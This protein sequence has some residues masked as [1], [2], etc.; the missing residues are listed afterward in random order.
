MVSLEDIKKLT[1]KNA[2]RNNWILNKDE[3]WLEDLNKG[4]YENQ[5]RYGYPSCPCRLASGD[6]KKDKDI[7]C[8]CDY[9]QP[10]ISEYGHCYCALFFDPDFYKNGKI[11]QKIPERR[12]KEKIPK[13]T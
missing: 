3:E 9:A 6:F 12:P 11:Q 7:I 4:L 5:K 8:P 1:K 10:D 13:S 2:E